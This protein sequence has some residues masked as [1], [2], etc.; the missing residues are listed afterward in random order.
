[1]F[2]EGGKP[3]DHPRGTCCPAAG[4]L[5]GMTLPGPQS[6]HRWLFSSVF[7]GPLPRGHGSEITPS[8]FLVCWCRFFFACSLFLQ[9]LPW[10]WEITLI[11]AQVRRRTCDSIDLEIPLVS[12][13]YSSPLIILLVFTPFV[14]PSSSTCLPHGSD[15]QRFDARTWGLR[16]GRSSVCAPGTDITPRS[17]VP[18]CTRGFLRMI[19]LVVF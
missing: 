3:T 19:F 4:A 5:H 8:F 1:M 14:Q 16:R 2:P 11:F 7:Q 10:Q 15:H 17:R 13:T 9:D 6:I 12:F 18:F